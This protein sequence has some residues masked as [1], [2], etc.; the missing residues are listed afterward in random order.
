MP[1]YQRPG[2]TGVGTEAGFYLTPGPSPRA[3]RG[4]LT[5]GVELI[6]LKIAYRKASSPF[7][8]GVRWGDVLPLLTFFL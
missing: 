2:K 5:E 6:L 3:E 1:P 7:G 4:E 8:G